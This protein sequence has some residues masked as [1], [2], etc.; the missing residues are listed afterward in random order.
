MASEQ[1]SRKE[2]RVLGAGK[3]YWGT[4]ARAMVRRALRARNRTIA[5]F[6][7]GQMVYDFLNNRGRAT[8][9][10]QRLGPARVV[11]VE[12]WTSG[13]PTE[14]WIVHGRNLLRAAPEQLRLAGHFGSRSLKSSVTSSVPAFG[15]EQVFCMSQNSQRGALKCL[16]GQARVLL[17]R[18]E[19]L[20]NG[21]SKV[22]IALDSLV[23]S[24]P[25]I[26]QGEK[27][28]IHWQI[29]PVFPEYVAPAPA[30]SYATPVPRAFAALFPVVERISPDFT[31]YAAPALVVESS[32]VG[33]V[34][35]PA[36]VVEYVSPD[37]AEYVAPARVVKYI[38]AETAASYAA[39]VP[40]AL[41]MYVSTSLQHQRQATACQRPQC[42]PHR[43]LSWN[44]ISQDP[45]VY[46]AKVPVEEFIAP[47]S[48]ASYSAAPTMF[49]APAPVVENIS[50]APAVYAT[51]DPVGEYI[52]PAPAV[53]YAAP[54]PVVEY[55]SPA[56]TVHVAPASVVE[57]I[58]TPTAGHAGPALAVEHTLP[59]PATAPVAEHI[60]PAPMDFVE[61][62]LHESDE[63]LCHDEIDELCYVVRMSHKRIWRRVW[64]SRS[65]PSDASKSERTWR[66]LS[67]RLCC[68]QE[69]D[70]MK[71]V[72][73]YC[74]MFEEED[75]VLVRCQ[76]PDC[77][78]RSADYE[79][80]GVFHGRCA[81]ALGHW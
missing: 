19:N 65:T 63:E 60:T 40:P 29:A 22:P 50:P 27:T 37:P 15:H 42:L 67:A 57:Y 48:V 62:S 45:T 47:A 43:S 44:I 34:A 1:F 41:A 5:E 21:S 52:S 49:A 80:P 20:V 75:D 25:V 71:R 12:P 28:E 55:F 72:C 9:S 79:I 13:V 68:E 14:I 2:K 3:V 38:A 17:K 46:A 18:M 36:P 6:Q 66:A 32:P 78:L 51:P 39:P 24:S 31:V 23:A 4:D 59:A 30:A 33:Y 16:A 61:A 10:L 26:V 74:G 69:F 7:P 70:E 76:G 81:A 77:S 35:A 58:A 54:A 11:F 56:P 53:S 73:A 64:H 8:T